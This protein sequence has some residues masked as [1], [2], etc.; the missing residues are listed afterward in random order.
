VLVDL[1]QHAEKETKESGT[2]WDII[3]LLLLVQILQLSKRLRIY[4]YTT[5]FIFKVLSALE[6]GCGLSVIHHLVS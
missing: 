5:D 4:D 3:L 6:M 1:Y 2:N